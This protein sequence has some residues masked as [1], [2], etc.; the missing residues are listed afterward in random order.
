MDKIEKG[1]RSIIEG[2]REQELNGI[3]VDALVVFARELLT[4]AKISRPITK[5]CLA[6]EKNT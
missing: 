3:Q 2:C 5:T 6:N 4:K 1:M